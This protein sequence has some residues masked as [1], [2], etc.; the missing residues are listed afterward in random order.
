MSRAMTAVVAAILALLVGIGVGWAIGANVGGDHM[1]G[2]GS[3]DHAA[4]MGQRE[5]LQMMIAHHQLAVGMSEAEIEA[6]DD[7]KVKAIA[8]TILAD[9]RREIAQMDAWYRALYGD[10]APSMGEQGAEMAGM[11]G[12][13]GMSPE[14]VS[15]AK[16]P[17][18]A[19]LRLMIPHHAGAIL[20]ADMV[21]ND[22]PDADVKALA[23][24]II[25][26]QSKEI[27]QMQAL[28]TTAGG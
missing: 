3:M 24:A 7:P 1:S 8:R 4:A 16:D 20:M 21:L 2:Q 17:D 5:F 13:A 11:L 22:S 10:G 25:A 23:E 6:G 27:A 26:A 18:Q 19:F 12:M 14:A 28:R 15:G 9:Q